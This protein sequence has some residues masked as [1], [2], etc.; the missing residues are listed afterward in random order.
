MIAEWDKK[1]PGRSWNVFG[2]LSRVVPTHLM[3][4]ELFDFAGLNPPGT[5]TENGDMAFDAESFDDAASIHG[6]DTD[7]DIEAGSAPSDG[8]AKAPAL[9]PAQQ[10]RETARTSHKI[11]FMANLQD[12]ASTE[13]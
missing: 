12:D 5:A 9:E 3:D 6:F 8:S 13:D 7:R 2:A 4:R 1:F 10:K 11:T